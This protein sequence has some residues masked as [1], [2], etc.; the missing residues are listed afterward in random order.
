MTKS[1][2]LRREG[3][4]GYESSKVEQGHTAWVLIGMLRNNL[5]LTKPM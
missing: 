3:C 5:L 1:W 2:G 4:E